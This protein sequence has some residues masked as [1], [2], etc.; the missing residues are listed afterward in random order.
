MRF[1]ILLLALL[2]SGQSAEIGERVSGFS[3]PDSSGKLHSLSDYR[4]K[5]TVLAFWSFKCPVS[6]AYNERL[7]ELQMKYRAQGIVLLGI[8]SNANESAEELRR[9]AANLKISFPLL[10]D[11][12]GSFAEK[13][14]V[15]H[16]PSMLIL[17][18]GGVLR[19]RGAPDNNK[20]PGTGGRIAYAEEALE[21]LLNGRP[22]Q[23]PET[24]EFG[25]S[26]QKRSF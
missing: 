22:L 15:H 20:I 25:C 16:T 11:S 6:L 1:S 18:S 9:N 8:A 24:K 26:I 19:Y 5:I 7:M 13:L 21:S 12:D 2:F 10:L 14:G 23:V 4:G 17:D 3:M